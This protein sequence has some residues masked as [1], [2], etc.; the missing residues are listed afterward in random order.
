MDELGDSERGA[1]FGLVRTVY[2]VIGSLGS[3]ATGLVADAFG[4][5]VAVGVLVALL[6]LVF[7]ALAVNWAF[8]LGY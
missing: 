5:A 6:T 8:G 4:W 1:G 3:V 7:L 2:G